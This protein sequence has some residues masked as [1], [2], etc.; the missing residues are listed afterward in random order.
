[1][2][3]V[4]QEYRNKSGEDI[5]HQVSYP[6]FDESKYSVFVP[7]KDQCDVCLGF[8]HGSVSKEEYEKHRKLK[9]QARDMKTKDKTEACNQVSA[10]TMDMQAVMVCPKSLASC[11]YYKTKLRLHNFTFYCFED[12]QDTTMH[13]MRSML[14]LVV[15]HLLGSDIKILIVWSDGCGYQNRNAIRSN[16]YLHLAKLMKVTIYQ[17]FGNSESLVTLRWSVTPCIA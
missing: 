2:N 9:D 8:K 16:A 1:M 6:V 12:K 11:M 7:R 3:S 13:G 5:V 4:F 15:K 17:K 14:T 10:W